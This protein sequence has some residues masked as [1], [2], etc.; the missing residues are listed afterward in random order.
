MSNKALTTEQFVEQ[1][2][3]IH[4]NFY[5]YSNTVYTFSCEKIEI[6]CPVHGGFTQQAASHKRGVGCPSCAGNAKLTTIGFLERANKKHNSKY[7]YLNISEVSH[8]TRIQIQC[9]EHGNFSQTVN[10]HLAGKGCPQCAAT[11][12][13]MKN[14]KPLSYFIE[15]SNELHDGKYNYDK[16]QYKLLSDVVTIT[17][18][19]HG[20]FEQRASYHITGRTACPKCVKHS[21]S[22]LD[23]EKILS[24][25]NIEYIREY[26][27]EGC[28]YKNKLPFDFFLPKYNVCIEYDGEQ[29]YIVKDHWGGESGLVLIRLRD[30]IK[31]DF[32]NKN[33][34]TLH[35]INYTENHKE[36][37]KN[38]IRSLHA[39]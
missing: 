17:C 23:I 9:N 1:C 22:V 34:I 3:K 38:I 7:S 15:K 16:V 29:H 24:S 12:I 10:D 20:D 33:G 30:S 6:L 32:C 27:F 13:G 26:K 19:E 4:N 11:L 35:R 39:K 14:R 18:P 36:K 2:K 28:K 25:E 31:T 37:I 8:G 5:D 21:K